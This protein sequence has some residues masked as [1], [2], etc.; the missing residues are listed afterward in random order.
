M[1]P[2][3]A[4]A[5]TIQGLIDG[6]VDVSLKVASGVVVILW[7]ATGILFLSAQGAPEKL[8]SAK[9]ALL[10]AVAGTIVVLVAEG[11]LDMVKNALNI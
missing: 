3:L 7:V 6:T 9:K 8:S 10:A 5:V 4:S 2:C 1:L 11:A